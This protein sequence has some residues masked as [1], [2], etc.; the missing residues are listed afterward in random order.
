[1]NK[2]LNEKEQFGRGLE[3]EEGEE[4]RKPNFLKVYHCA[5]FI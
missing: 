1:V 5:P 3:E 2:V 4:K